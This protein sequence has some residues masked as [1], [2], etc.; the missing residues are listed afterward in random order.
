[1]IGNRIS[2]YLYD[3]L[4]SD[5]NEKGVWPFKVWLGPLL[6]IKILFKA[7]QLLSKHVPSSLSL[8]IFYFS[9]HKDNDTSAIPQSN[10][11]DLVRFPHFLRFHKFFNNFYLSKYPYK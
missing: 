4:F 2:G 5:S 11:Q 9:F 8:C 10:I 6:F 3:E 1:M 7:V